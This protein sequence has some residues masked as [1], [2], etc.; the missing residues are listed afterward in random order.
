MSNPSKES[1]SGLLWLSVVMVGSEGVGIRFNQW[2][3]LGLGLTRYVGPCLNLM[4]Q[5]LKG[6]EIV[7]QSRVVVTC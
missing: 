7:T 1:V 3:G 2:A 6:L 5:Q 4:L